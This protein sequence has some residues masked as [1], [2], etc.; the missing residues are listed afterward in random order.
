MKIRDRVKELRRVPVSQ[1]RAHPHNWRRHGAH[2]RAALRGLFAE[3][4]YADA[5]LAYELPDGTLQLIDG[6]LR[7]DAAPDAIAPVLVLDV[8]ADEAE[9]LLLTHDPLAAMAETD[10]ELL[11]DSLA[12]VD[13]A[14][15]AVTQMLAELAAETPEAPLLAEVAAR[16][17]L[18]IRESF[19]IVVD[20]RD[21]TQQAEL[22]QRL[23]KE[24]YA[25]RV[26]SLP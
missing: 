17:E 14:A 13:F 3:I 8:D 5:L 11:A 10:S 23:C 20:C 4:G 12:R 18:A 21:E 7:V 19:Q 1:L 2:Q 22:Y 25:C 24:G 6:H 26:L 15:S 9:K 16:P